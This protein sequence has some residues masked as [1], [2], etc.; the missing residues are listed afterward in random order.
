[1]GV[2]A[3]L[4][5]AGWWCSRGGSQA[6]A[7]PG[8]DSAKAAE[9]GPLDAGQVVDATDQ[10]VQGAT[11]RGQV[12]A[13]G[14]PVE[15]ARIGLYYLA[16]TGPTGDAGPYVV[17][18][19]AESDK[20]GEF[21]LDGIAPGR[22]KL[23]VEADDYALTESKQIVVE[24]TETYGPVVVDL[25]P[26]ASITGVVTDA[27]G[28]PVR[29]TVVL[30]GGP[31]ERSRRVEAGPGGRYIFDDLPE[32]DFQ[33]EARAD[34][35]RVELVD[36]VRAE[37]EQTVSR[38]I[39]M[40]AARGIFGRVVGPDGAGVADASVIVRPKQGRGKVLR[41]Q[42][43]GRFQWGEPERGVFAV[44]AHSPHYASSASQSVEPG[45]PIRLRLGEGGAVSGQVVGPHGEPVPVYSIGVD[46]FQ[47]DGPRP[48]GAKRIGVLQIDD[49]SG[50]F[51][52]DSLRPGA[53]WF[54]VRTARYASETSA[55]V[56]VRAGAERSDVTIQ[57]GRVG[58]VSGRVTDSNTD[59]PL[60]GATVE[61]FTA[62]GPF[63]PPAAQTDSQGRYRVDEIPPGLNSLI[64]SK[65][66]YVRTIASGIE[67][68]AGREVTRDIVVRPQ[69][70]GE[71]MQFQGIGAMLGKTKQGVLVRKVFE[72][73]P[74]SQA[75]LT[76]GD[77]I[78][79]VDGQSVDELP[80]DAVVERI[81][82]QQG[83]PVELEIDRKG[84]GRMT[85][86]IERGEV[87][88]KR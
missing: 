81:R 84:K 80:L 8:D 35:Y 44:G 82:G 69:K 59:K 79:A 41:T 29:A 68:V 53:Y 43:D 48:Y 26:S 78:L 54:Q 17:D 61:L 45:V 32:G 34:G 13:S 5:V 37:V 38:D 55:R 65:K 60:A 1:M 47:V 83:E 3:L 66:G 10:P 87:V 56:I 4:A 42:A 36:E 9:T 85:L 62:D 24:P 63:K 2:I 28:Q 19:A 67:I 25:D 6:A 27:D 21:E 64:V 72:G 30:R 7:P 33:I 86:E 31:L 88:V 52:Y 57:V 75:G 23:L 12:V 73:R 51:R 18:G 16:A 15:A 22:V 14:R 77:H 70:K 76:R 20:N 46:S 74:A 11:V 58:T 71:R 40:E 39:V 49:P 50:R